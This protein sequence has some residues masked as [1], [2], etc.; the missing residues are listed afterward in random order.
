MAGNENARAEGKT[1]TIIEELE[2]I[3]GFGFYE[4]TKTPIYDEDGNYKGLIGVN[5]NITQQKKDEK[6]I[7]RI[8][9]Q[10]YHMKLRTAP[11]ARLEGRYP[12]ALLTMKPEKAPCSV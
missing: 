8:T 11:K 7:D 2:L 9:T 4:N 12:L 3:D 6:A 5:R 1:V 10:L